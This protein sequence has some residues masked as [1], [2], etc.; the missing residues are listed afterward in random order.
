M[1]KT[2]GI[3]V[4]MEIHEILK[5]DK[6]NEGRGSRSKDRNGRNEKV[7][8]GEFLAADTFLAIKPK[9]STHVDHFHLTFSDESTSPL[10]PIPAWS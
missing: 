7:S 9:Q 5:A 2:L 3:A 4:A 1:E 8:W 10:S 6:K